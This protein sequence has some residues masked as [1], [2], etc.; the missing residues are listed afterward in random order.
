[1]K[2]I[3]FSVL[4]TTGCAFMLVLVSCRKDIKQEETVGL[5]TAVSPE[6]T[7]CNIQRFTTNDPFFGTGFAEFIYN[8]AGNP[9]YVVPR[10]NPDYRIAH[11]FRYDAANRLT[12]HIFGSSKGFY[13]AWARFN[14][15]SSTSTRIATSFHY[16]NGLVGTNPTSTP[17][18]YTI[19]FYDEA[20]R[21][22]KTITYLHGEHPSVT[23]TYQYNAAGNLIREGVVY[24]D[25]VHL[26]RT[27]SVWMFI[28]RNYSMNNPLS[29]SAYNQQGLPTIFNN[30]TAQKEFFLGSLPLNRSTI[31]Y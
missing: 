4:C 20:G 13:Q 11:E 24:D 1:M 31:T 19:Y 29:A 2:K 21:I 10:F 9:I 17:I 14:Y 27:S 3:L 7:V 23:Q 15:E 12:D 28:D 25:K 8:A 16:R 26:R 6:L 5:V 18:A 30:S 22:I